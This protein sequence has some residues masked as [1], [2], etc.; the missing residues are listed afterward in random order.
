MSSSRSI[1]W[2]I[3]AGGILALLPDAV[4]AQTR[5][6]TI[7]D[8]ASQVLNEF[9]SIPNRNIP[10]ALV[11]RA[12]GVVIV[13]SAVK[14]GLIAGV[15][16]GKGVVVVRDDRGGWRPPTFVTMTG[17]SVGWQ[18]G[19]QATDV[20]LVFTT[21]RSIQGLL[22]G[23]FTIGVD[24]AAAAGPVG[25][26]ASAATDG[27]LQAE[28]YSYSRSRG[29]FA[30]VSVDGAVLQNDAT[31]NQLFYRPAGLM[32]DGTPLQ[33]NAKMPAA[34][35]RL[36][37]QLAA[38]SGSPVAGGS[39]AGIAGQGGTLPSTVVPGTVDPGSAGPSVSSP[40]PG[41]SGTRLSGIPDPPSQ[42]A[43]SAAGA[44]TS[45]RLEQTRRQLADTASHLGALL[46]DSWRNYL[47]LPRAVFSGQGRPSLVSLENSVMRFDR[48]AGDTRYQVLLDRAEFQEARRLLKD[49]TRQIRLA[50]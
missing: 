36:L 28:I 30:G 9:M 41:G 47:A 37:L 17:G 50:R 19:V 31:S 2:G 22:R 26:Q 33:A 29:L 10:Q 18:V 42:N 12:Q 25:R 43:P 8:S 4:L 7:V 40:I 16:R 14:V 5:E 49:Y 11:V 46:D 45:D 48:V 27:R 20:I 32:P 1:L 3:A 34:A 15:R 21:R 38:Y 13:P 24:A 35:S 6:A 23:K 44:N 39:T